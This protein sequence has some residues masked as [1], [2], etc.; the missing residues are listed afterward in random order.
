MKKIIFIIILLYV[1]CKYD[2]CGYVGSSNDPE[3]SDR[4]LEASSDC[5]LF[6]WKYYNY[7][8]YSC[9]SRSKIMEIRNYYNMTDNFI[10]DLDD[11]IYNELNKITF[12]KCNNEDGIL[13]HSNIKIPEPISYRGLYFAQTVEVEEV[14]IYDTLSVIYYKLINLI[15]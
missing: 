5:C 4:C 7:V 15:P 2:P 10:Y 6:I 3:I 11:D 12:S 9:S 13:T 8:Y 14:T 1:S